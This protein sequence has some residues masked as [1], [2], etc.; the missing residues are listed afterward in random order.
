MGWGEFVAAFAAFFLSHSLPLRPSLR[1]WLTAW[2]GARGFTLAYSALSVAILAWLID[3]AGRAPF[4][5][6]WTWAPWQH[7][8]TLLAMLAVC[9]IVAFAV[10]R[11]NPFSFGGGRAGFDPARPGIVRLL[12]HPLL[13]ALALWAFAHLIPNGDLAHV[14]LFGIFGIFALIGHVLVDRRRRRAL[15]SEWQRLDGAVRR[16]LVVPRP[17]TWTGAIVRL[18]VGIALYTGLIAVHPLLFGVSPLP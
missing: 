5:P 14:L 18:G 11:P 7:N 3:A 15:G 9:L 4:V 13:A 8:V 2:L 6:L 16:G 1:P 10:A 17:A 12:R